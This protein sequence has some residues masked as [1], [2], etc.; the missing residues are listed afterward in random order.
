MRDASLREQIA[1]HGQQ[2]GQGFG[3]RH[4][5]MGALQFGGFPLAAGFLRAEVGAES[6][7]GASETAA[8]PPYRGKQRE[9]EQEYLCHPP[10]YRGGRGG[11]QT[12]GR[13]RG[14]LSGPVRVLP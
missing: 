4:A 7:Q 2:R 14:A 10:E 13:P 9:A 5:Q 6:G 11:M 1:G 8:G 12:K 3:G